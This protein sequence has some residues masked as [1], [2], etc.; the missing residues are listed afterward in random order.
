M[1]GQGTSAST[2]LC[3]ESLSIYSHVVV[4][5]VTLYL[6]SWALFAVKSSCGPG[7]R[8][9]GIPRRIPRWVQWRRLDETL[10]DQCPQPHPPTPEGPL[11]RC[12]TSSVN[13]SRI[14]TAIIACTSEGLD[15][16]WPLAWRILRR[17]K[18]CIIY[19]FYKAVAGITVGPRRRNRLM[20]PLV[21]YDKCA[22][23]LQ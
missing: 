7:R 6:L 2:L 18:T 11:G 21:L 9:I 20:T 16:P 13:A 5:R 15:F 1:K 8:D 12:H 23:C 17:W 22:K 4:P 3:C 14:A 19:L 10:G